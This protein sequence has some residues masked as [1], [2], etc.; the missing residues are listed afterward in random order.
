MVQ[1]FLLVVDDDL[2][3]RTRVCRALRERGYV[4][5]EAANGAEAL[6]LIRSRTPDVIVTDIMMP[7]GDGIEFISAVRRS[8]LPSRI[9]AVSGSRDIRSLDFLKMAEKL[10]ADASLRKPFTL[11]ELLEALRSLEPGDEG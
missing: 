3:F 8:G 5:I 1:T 10:G 2:P 11:D 4:A 7:D 9:L 6:T